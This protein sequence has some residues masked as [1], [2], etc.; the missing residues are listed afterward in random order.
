M[1]M[2]DLKGTTKILK[3]AADE[4]RLRML[5]LLHCRPGVCVCE[6][7]KVIGLSQPTISSHLRLLESAGLVES[8]KEGLWVNY[9]L[10]QD[11]D[12]EAKTII[13]LLHARLKED[14]QIKE[15]LNKIQKTDRHAI[16][17]R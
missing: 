12:Q 15:D 6:I 9:R 13:G 11:M 8:Q 4:G 14:P 10:A 17:K 3:A 16:C 2:K 5:M 7:K 1:E